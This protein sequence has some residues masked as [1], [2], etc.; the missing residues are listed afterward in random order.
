MRS[1]T[2]LSWSCINW[3]FHF[4]TMPPKIE[5]ACE[6]IITACMSQL[7]EMME[8]EFSKRQSTTKP[9]PENL[10][11]KPNPCF[12]PSDGSNPL[13]L[14]FSRWTILQTHPKP[15]T[16][17]THL[18]SFIY[19]RHHTRMVQMVAFEPWTRHAGNL[20]KSIG[21]PFWY[22]GLWK[23]SSGLVQTE[24]W[25]D[26]SWSTRPNLSHWQTE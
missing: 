20:Y 3:C 18:C 17:M 19:A 22:V 26:L 11:K 4:L 24:D 12:S 8:A 23:P 2:T 21:M 10:P 16:T 6:E 13:I 7:K 9:P 25:W 15:A 5:N 14:D 1:F